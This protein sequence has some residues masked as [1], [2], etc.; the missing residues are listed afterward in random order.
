VADD[1]QVRPGGGTHP[2]VL[3]DEVSRSGGTTAHI[4]R[5]R[6][7]GAAEGYEF[8]LTGDDGLMTER[9]GERLCA[10]IEQANEYLELIAEA[11]G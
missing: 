1:I 7:D 10:L 8:A 3:T 9:T 2:Y 6:L 5:V 4:Q 11:L